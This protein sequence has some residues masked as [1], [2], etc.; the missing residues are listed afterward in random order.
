M[1]RWV[2]LSVL[3]ILIACVANVG[4]LNHKAVDFQ[5]DVYYTQ[6]RTTQLLDGLYEQVKINDKCLY[7]QIAKLRNQKDL[8]QV[9]SEVINSVV[10]VET[11]N[12]WGS[13]FAI[14]ENQIMTARHVVMGVSEV[15]IVSEDN[16]EYKSIS[17]VQH[18]DFDV[19]I[20]T[21]TENVFKSLV[22][23]ISPVQVG[24]KVFAIGSPRDLSNK[25]I[26]TQGFVAGINR[27]YVSPEKDIYWPNLFIVDMSLWYG[28]S[29]CPVFNQKGEVIG[30]FVGSV[31]MPV[32]NNCI[33][34]EI[35]IEW[36]KT[37]NKVGDVR[38]L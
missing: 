10:L 27:S 21:I 14:S 2:Q 31:S 24:D 22:V 35:L 28:N 37:I 11:E 34:S 17:I 9:V 3:S 20:I 18:P 23:N 29:G 30:M 13:G 6:G 12:G 1:K 32:F 16:K 33:P 26:L 5:R 36:V 19:A 15:K 4:Y 25:N 7:D 8:S 38:C